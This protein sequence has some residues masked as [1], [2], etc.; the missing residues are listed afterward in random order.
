MKRASTPSKPA[1]EKGPRD[2]DAYLST[3][4]PGARRKLQALR[5]AI[6]AAAP[7][8]VEGFSYGVP[9]IRIGGRPVVGYAAA[10]AHYSL[11]PMSGRVM[12]AFAVDLRAY[13]TSKGTIR[14]AMDKP[15]PTQLVRRIV[16]ARLAELGTAKK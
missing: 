7:G 3:L 11:F 14:F 6:L 9:A 2:V 12:Q 8:A 16:K 15:L 4:T 5:G 13:D 10:R 1:G